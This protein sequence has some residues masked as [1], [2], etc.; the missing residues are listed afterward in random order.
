MKIVEEPK[1]RAS[2]VVKEPRRALQMKAVDALLGTGML[3]RVFWVV[4]LVK[5][6][7]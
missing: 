2:L 3:Y 6:F 7:T 1:R 4:G 5:M